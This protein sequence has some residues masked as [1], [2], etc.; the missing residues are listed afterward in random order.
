MLSAACNY[1]WTLPADTTSAT[2]GT[3]ASGGFGGSG[4]SGGAGGQASGG[5][6]GEAGMGGAGGAMCPPD[7]GDHACTACLKSNCC[8]E[9]LACVDETGCDCWLDCLI[10]GNNCNNCGVPSAAAQ[11]LILCGASPCQST[12]SIPP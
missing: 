9:Y 5:G 4:G 3:V 6:G 8:S 10:T 12:C 11:A 2:G 7:G 1:D